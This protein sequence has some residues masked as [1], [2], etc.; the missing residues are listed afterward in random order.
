VVAVG[1]G[2]ESTAISRDLLLDGR[3]RFDLR[4]TVAWVSG[5]GLSVWA[6]YGPEAT[7][8]PRR[9]LL[10][11]LRA[12]F[13]YPLAKFAIT[14]DDRPMLMTELPPGAGDRDELGRALARMA[15]IGDRLLDE[16]APAVAE[17]GLLPD[18]SGRQSRNG[19]LLERYGPEVASVMPDWEPPHLRPAR[20][21][22]L[23]RL[24]GRQP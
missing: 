6:Y 15:I 18:W 2:D 23:R 19:P 17:R 5:V 3:R 22:L 4:V 14:E 11:M 8:I 24:F 1:K 21:G 13:D 7:E 12:N 16:T 10:R 20:R 9:V